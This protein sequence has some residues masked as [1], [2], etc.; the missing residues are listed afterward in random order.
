[1]WILI[2]IRLEYGLKIEAVLDLGGLPC[3]KIGGAFLRC[4]NPKH[5]HSYEIRYFL[6][7]A[8]VPLGKWLKW[9]FCYLG[10]IKIGVLVSIGI[11]E[12]TAMWVGWW[13]RMVL[14]CGVPWRNGC[15]GKPLFIVPLVFGMNSRPLNSSVLPKLDPQVVCLGQQ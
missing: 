12:R 2:Q 14:Q 6:L 10:P 13:G 11:L 4:S 7:L 15:M 1:M 8:L 9:D 3:Q 5:S